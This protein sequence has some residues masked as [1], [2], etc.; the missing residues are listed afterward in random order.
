MN[1]NAILAC[2]LH[3]RASVMWPLMA[4]DFMFVALYSN[5]N[6]SIALGL[7]KPKNCAFSPSGYPPPVRPILR[8][9]KSLN[10]SPHLS[11]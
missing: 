2:R 5:A 9:Q 4:D 3:R 7:K 11:F 1:V 10:L 8:G 6:V